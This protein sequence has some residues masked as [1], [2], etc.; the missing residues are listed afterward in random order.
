MRKIRV[1][2]VLTVLL[3]VPLVLSMAPGLAQVET[4]PE[5]ARPTWTPLPE[6]Q[7]PGEP[8][9]PPPVVPG[10]SV[11]PISPV[12]LPS[13]VP[14]SPLPGSPRP[15]PRPSQTLRPFTGRLDLNVTR[16]DEMRWRY[17]VVNGTDDSVSSIFLAVPTWLYD[18]RLVPS[19]PGGW[20]HRRQPGEGAW[21]DQW[22]LSWMSGAEGASLK[23]GSVVDLD[24]SSG[25]PLQ[26][27][28]YRGRMLFGAGPADRMVFP[29]DSDFL[30]VSPMVPSFGQA[31]AR[32]IAGVQYPQMAVDLPRRPVVAMPEAVRRRRLSVEVIGQG[33]HFG[34]V[35]VAV[36]R[37]PYQM[38]AELA[39]GTVMLPSMEGYDDII[40]GQPERLMLKPTDVVT[41][42]FRGYSISYG[43][44]APPMRVQERLLQYSFSETHRHLDA[45]RSI[46][47]RAHGLRPPIYT[48]VGQD[49]ADMI[50]QWALWRQER[51]LDGNPLDIRDVERDLTL[52]YR[53]VFDF[54]APGMQK[55][56]YL[57]PVQVR[58]VAREVWSQSDRLLY[59]DPSPGPMP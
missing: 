12:T 6:G 19:T 9:P 57:G 34:E 1:V 35:F 37:T 26:L 11:E 29:W 27:D 50:V 52:Y 53:W 32:E 38:V 56:E 39:E 5:P 13:A 51:I 40:V 45:Y 18:S 10:G 22:I 16:L 46:L 59:G 47:R 4:Q 21:K 43:R 58:L 3:L 25:A 8:G 15:R 41:M 54:K 17:R 44:K 23:P 36:I 7:G 49:L 20:I 33:R 24:L 30:P 55:R 42:R 2:L 48:P 28:Q 31:P 14:G